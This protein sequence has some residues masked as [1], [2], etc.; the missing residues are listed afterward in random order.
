MENTQ[1]NIHHNLVHFLFVGQ[2]LLGG[3]NDPLE[4]DEGA[5]D[6]GT[7]DMGSDDTGTGDT[8]SA[9]DAI[10]GYIDLG[11]D[12]TKPKSAP[13]YSYQNQFV[14]GDFDNDGRVDDIVYYSS[15]NRWTAYIEN[16]PWFNLEEHYGD[17]MWFAGTDARFTPVV[18]D[19]DNDGY[20]DDIVYWG[21]CG[22]Q[23]ANCWR[24][25]RGDGTKLL[26]PESMGDSMWFAHADPRS[27]PVVGDFDHDHFEDDILYYGLCGNYV[28][29]WRLHRGNVNNFLPPESMGGDMWFATDDS[30]STPVVGDFNGSGYKDDI[31]YLGLCG[32]GVECWRV[33]LRNANNTAFTVAGSASNSWFVF[34]DSRSRPFSGDFDGDGRHD[35]IAYYGRFGNSVIG[36]RIHIGNG[37]GSFGVNTAT[38]QSSLYKGFSPV[39]GDFGGDSSSDI[40]YVAECGEWVYGW[41]GWWYET[42]P[43]LATA[44]E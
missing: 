34:S 4:V 30:R 41:F 44:L 2:L 32:A 3:C 38:L 27:T 23:Q 26:P 8:G 24:R 43:C 14:V 42:Y 39:A 1:S 18:G 25:H 16:G 28:E 36:W 7:G 15:P 35:D 17:S 37:N 40:A 11:S 12:E 31:A 9:S 33:H 29:C 13:V 10:F 19:F 22:N 6:T 5:G 20:K 21:L